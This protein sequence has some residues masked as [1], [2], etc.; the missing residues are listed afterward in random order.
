LAPGVY[1][2][3]APDPLPPPCY[4][5][6]EYSICTPTPYAHREGGRGG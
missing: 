4:I 1:L 3:E 2:S 6:Y 5:L